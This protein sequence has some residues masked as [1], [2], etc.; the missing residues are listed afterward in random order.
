[1]GASECSGSGRS[2]IGNIGQAI[3]GLTGGLAERGGMTAVHMNPSAIHFSDADLGEDDFIAAVGS[4]EVFNHVKWIGVVYFYVRCQADL[5]KM[6]VHDK[7]KGDMVIVGDHT[8]NELRV[9]IYKIPWQIE[10]QPPK[11]EMLTG[12]T[13]KIS[14]AGVS[15]S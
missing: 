6:W 11:W 1:M 13:E 2:A 5:G 8:A 12:P 14:A 4:P 7:C 9:N 3:D 10:C 15:L